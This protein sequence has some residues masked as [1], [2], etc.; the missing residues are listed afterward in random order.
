MA[1]KIPLILM[2]LLLVPL[3]GLRAADKELGSGVETWQ[4][5]K[6]PEAE[7]PYRDNQ[8]KKPD[9]V[10]ESRFTP[11]YANPV[12]FE[13]N[14]F[15]PVTLK[16][17]IHKIIEG[18]SF[19]DAKTGAY[20]PFYEFAYKSRRG[21]LCV[22]SWV[23]GSSDVWAAFQNKD[24]TWTPP[25]F[26]GDIKN[27]YKTSNEKIQN[28]MKFAERNEIRPRIE[29]IDAEINGKVL[30][31]NVI[32]YLGKEYDERI[33]IDFYVNVDLDKV[34]SDL[35]RDGV[36]DLLEPQLGTSPDNSDSDR[37]GIPDLNDTNPTES[38]KEQSDYCDMVNAIFEYH[39]PDSELEERHVLFIEYK[40]TNIA[41]SIRMNIDGVIITDGKGFSGGETARGFISFDKP[42]YRKDGS[43]LINVSFFFGR[44]WGYGYEYIFE[45]INKKWELIQVQR[46]WVS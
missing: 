26:V 37:D 19:G 2:V 17:N 7:Y 3:A 40:Q 42:E 8:G 20:F 27:S 16:K 6:R 4:L 45:K 29:R 18:N 31:Y 44:L 43:V 36:S 32:T 13:N 34:T 23:R 30:A 21:V 15:D 41:C 1:K 38:F 11:F 35:D 12:T 39:Y 33:E 25:Y 28:F 14:E 46:D 9:Y 10:R 22:S 5:A 24:G